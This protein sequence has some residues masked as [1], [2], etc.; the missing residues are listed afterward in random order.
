MTL[1][2]AMSKQVLAEGIESAHQLSILQDLGCE[3]GQGFLLSRPVDPKA[4]AGI[5]ARRASAT[6]A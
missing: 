2:R 6:P 1:G 5:L 3:F 4:V